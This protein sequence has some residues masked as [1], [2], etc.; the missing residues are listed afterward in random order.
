MDPGLNHLAG[1]RVE[2]TSL[3]LGKEGKADFKA[4]TFIPNN[5]L[6]AFNLVSDSI[7]PPYFAAAP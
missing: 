5:S 7:P 6:V 4:K 1:I 2:P 3:A